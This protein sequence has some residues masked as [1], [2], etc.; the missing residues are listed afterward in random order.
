MV[1]AEGEKGSLK[2]PKGRPFSVGF[3]E[4]APYN[5]VE[6]GRVRLEALPMSVSMS[7]R[8]AFTNKALAM[9]ANRFPR[10]LSSLG[11]MGDKYVVAKQ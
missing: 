1:L 5:C 6:D 8:V 7:S 3:K 11:P 4:T 9:E 10:P 2:L